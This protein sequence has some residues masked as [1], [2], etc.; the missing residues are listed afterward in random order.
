M[1]TSNL[2]EESVTSTFRVV[3]EMGY[4]PEVGERNF[5]SNFGTFI[6]NYKAPCCV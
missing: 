4:N 6:L 3:A 5:L 2:P 1:S